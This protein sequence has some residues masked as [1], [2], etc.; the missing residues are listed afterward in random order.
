MLTSKLLAFSVFS[1][2]V[3]QSVLHRAVP[4]NRSTA[5]Q[6]TDGPSKRGLLARHATPPV[7]HVISLLVHLPPNASV[8][9]CGQ[10]TCCAKRNG[11]VC[12]WHANLQDDTLHLTTLDPSKPGQA[13]REDAK[14]MQ[15][16]AAD[17]PLEG[18]TVTVVTE[19]LR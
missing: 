1:E 5:R 10:I 8:G 17:I 19:G 15:Q 7:L 18:C 3:L 2:P 14:G 12:R 6:A 16:A 9:Q 4:S 11:S 13:G